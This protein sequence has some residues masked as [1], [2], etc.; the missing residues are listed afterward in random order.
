MEKTTKRIHSKDCL[1][2]IGYA[3]LR[4][5]K[6][7]QAKKVTLCKENN[8]KKANLSEEVKASQRRRLKKK[9]QAPKLLI[10]NLEVATKE[11][12]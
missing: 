10:E 9:T 6:I 5:Q 8:V 12:N 11:L 4:P 3:F 7:K 1:K 2:K